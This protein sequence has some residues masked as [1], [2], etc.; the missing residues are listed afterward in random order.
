MIDRT[1]IE[2]LVHD[3]Y[4]DI[5]R[6]DLLGPLFTGIIGDD[7]SVH[8]A[9]MVEFWSTVMLGTRSFRGNVF[10]KHMAVAGVR[11]EHF[12]RWL[13]LWHR[14]TNRLFGTE[15]AAELQRTAHGIARNLFYGFFGEFPT[16]VMRDGV[17]VG[18]VP[19]ERPAP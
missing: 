16:F 3:F 10:G 17:A 9:R 11:P 2:T 12:L 5:G 4:R 6:D 18:H 1:K 8:L 15:T 14:H 7:W 13:T 19:E